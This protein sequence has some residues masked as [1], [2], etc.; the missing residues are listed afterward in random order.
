MIGKI[1]SLAEARGWKALEKAL[2]RDQAFEAKWGTNN[3]VH[4]TNRY[5]PTQESLGHGIELVAVAKPG[6]KAAGI[7]TFWQDIYK[8]KTLGFDLIDILQGGSPD[9]PARGKISQK[10]KAMQLF[11]P[12]K[13]AP[14][15][16]FHQRKGANPDKWR[17][18]DL[19]AGHTLARG[20]MAEALLDFVK[21]RESEPSIFF[22][23][24]SSL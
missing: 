13:D 10:V 12:T 22:A 24:G 15:W 20:K 14:Y 7:P 21:K 1:I 16:D 19:Q 4:T 9:M 11:G 18:R 17:P 3:P 2:K 6:S 8:D 23:D 5:N